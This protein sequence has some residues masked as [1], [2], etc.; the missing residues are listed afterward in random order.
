[1]TDHLASILAKLRVEKGS[2]CA[3]PRALLEEVVSDLWRDPAEQA[4]AWVA[5]R[6]FLSAAV[7]DQSGGALE[8][9]FSSREAREHQPWRIHAERAQVQLD[10]ANRAFAQDGCFEEL[11]SIFLA[12][13][14]AGLVNETVAT[15]LGHLLCGSG[16][17][18][19]RFFL[20]YLLLVVPPA[21]RR[22]VHNWAVAGSMPTAARE[23]HGEAIAACRAALYPDEGGFEV[24]NARL[25]A[26]VSPV[27][28]AGPRAGSGLFDDPPPY[29]RVLEGA[30]ALAIYGP[31]GDQTGALDTTA[32][33][34]ALAGLKADIAR[35][36]RGRGGGRGRGWAQRPL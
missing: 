13:A 23:A 8:K 12:Q 25:L 18:F 27:Q 17:E 16:G 21:S 36:G 20:A 9:Y 29:R 28:G 4:Q 19:G 33:E 31:S 35:V 34:T 22:S 1:M 30:G 7:S 3:L 24:L 32:L 14:R 11:R 5:M 26:G 6:P 10:A 2:L 15:V